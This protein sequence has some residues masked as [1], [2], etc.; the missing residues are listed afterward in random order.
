MVFTE[1]VTDDT[2]TLDG[3]SVR[4]QPQALHRVENTALNRFH[5]VADIRKRAPLNDGNRILQIGAACEISQCQFINIR[6]GVL[7]RLFND[8]CSAEHRWLRD[9]FRVN[10]FRFNFFNYGFFVFGVLLN[11]L[12]RGAFCLRD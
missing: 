9:H 2:R 5:A 12:S 4:G 3:F 10:D 11:Q 8:V 1:H 7:H 6:F